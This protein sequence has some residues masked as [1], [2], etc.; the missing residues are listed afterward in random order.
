MNPESG[1]GFT[2]KDRT[3]Q[4]NGRLEFTQYLG[5]DGHLHSIWEARCDCGA[6]IQTAH[7]TKVR[8]CGCL[9]R[10]IAAAT[11]RAKAFPPELRRER[12]KQNA[13]RQR[14]KRKTDPLKAMQARLSR[15]HRHALAM[16]GAIKTSPTFEQLGYT[17][18]DFVE[19]IERQFLKG[20]GWH[21]MDQWQLDHILPVSGANSEEDVIALNQLSNLRPMWAAEN[22]AKKDKRVSLI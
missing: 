17:V 11:Q 14:A 7:P 4:R 2:F 5:R 19:H 21:N 15:L 8:S 18:E 1:R 12:L 9:H 13:A 22:N 10:E 20:M 6:V 16:V 3:G